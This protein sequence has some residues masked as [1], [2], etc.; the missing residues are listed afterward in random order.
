MQPD[1]TQR[2]HSKIMIAKKHV[3]EFDVR[4]SIFNSMI[5]SLFVEDVPELLRLVDWIGGIYTK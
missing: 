2:R 3:Y 1:F 4:S 5:L